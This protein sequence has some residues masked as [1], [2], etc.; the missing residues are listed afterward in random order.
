MQPSIPRTVLD[1]P[2]GDRLPERG[3]FLQIASGVRWIRMPLPFALDHINLWLLRDRIDEREGWT[4]VDCGADTPEARAA[5]DQVI[6]NGL[7][8]LP[9]LRVVVTHMH[10]DHIGLAHWLCARFAAPLWI[11]A[12]DYQVARIGVYDEDGFGGESGVAFYRQHGYSTPDFVAHVRERRRYYPRLV[13]ALPSQFE[14]LA[15]GDTVHI[16]ADAWHALDGYGH[17]PEHI[18]LHCAGRNLLISGDM[19]LPSISTNVSVHASEPEADPLGLFLQSLQRYESLPM[20]SLVLPS[21]GRP[22]VGLHTRLRALQTHH[23]ERLAALLAACEGA[24]CSAAQALPVLF[25]RTLDTHQ[26]TFALGEAV[27]HL[28]RL[29]KEGQVVR[30][31]S[32]EGS[33]RFVRV[34]T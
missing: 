33:H 34:A 9:L 31:T 8:G 22:F 10:P 7:D 26:T 29:W 6:E 14:R 17:A 1:Y 28:H 21:H 4:L 13:P 23:A 24:G 20:E 2:L 19:V 11:S 18:M 30:T 12:T 5:W 3:G 15:D 16:G 25:Q 27:A 32:T